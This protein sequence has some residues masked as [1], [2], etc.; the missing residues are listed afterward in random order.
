MTVMVERQERSDDEESSS[1]GP[2]SVAAVA[3][4]LGVAPSTLRTWDRRY[5]LGPE[6]HSIGAH[7]R[8]TGSDLQRLLVM[9][10]LTLDGVPP[11]EAARLAKS[12]G[13]RLAPEVPA[14]V[15][16]G[17]AAPETVGTVTV[18]SGGA[19]AG[20][21]GLYRAAAA[22]DFLEIARLLRASLDSHGIASTW[23]DLA[24]PVLS[25]IGERWELTGEGVE[26]EH[27]LSQVLLS[28]LHSERP[29]PL[30]PV[31][32]RPVLL[33]CADGEYHALVLS[34]LDYAL[35]ERGILSRVFGPGLP[36]QA[37]VDAARRSGPAAV[38]LFAR[39]PTSDDLLLADL[40]RQRPAPRV[41]VGGTGWEPGGLPGGVRRV[42]TLDEAVS[43]IEDAVSV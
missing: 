23:N 20:T 7:R 25:R 32:T 14:A 2:F 10:R 30:R 35:A 41:I 5:D 39:L 13:A 38:F 6:D 17:L 31:N 34:V 43:E 33:A 21:R 29:L 9:R 37:I 24:L 36:R 40:P 1:P 11:G 15:V 3:R 16:E 12:Q 28:V 4:R 19:E 8:Y 18:R 42:G 27:A 22:L 26:V